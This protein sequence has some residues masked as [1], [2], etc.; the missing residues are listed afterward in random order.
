MELKSIGK[1]AK[2]I[3]VTTIDVGIKGKK[4]EDRNSSKNEPTG[5]F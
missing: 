1:F 5:N 2:R 4:K 3:G